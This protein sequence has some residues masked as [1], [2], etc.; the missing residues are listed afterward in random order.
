VGRGLL[1]GA[2]VI[3]AGGKLVL[4][5]YHGFMRLAVVLTIYDRLEVLPEQLKQLANQSDKDFDL[6]ICNNSTKN[7][8]HLKKIIDF[9]SVTYANKYIFFGRIFMIRDHI[10]PKGYDAIFTIDDDETLPANLIDQCKRQFHPNAIRSFWAFK[11]YDDYW[12]RKRLKG[13]QTG[14]YAGMGGCL[15]P[16][17][18]W[19]LEAIYEAP[20]ECW[21]VDDLW[22]SHC[23]LKHTN[24]AIKSLN[25]SMS[26][27]PSEGKKATYR[28]IKPFKSE[29]HEKYI[30]PYRK[31]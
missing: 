24:Y 2:G 29:I 16:A 1:D 11:T 21:M 4:V 17:K 5:I 9:E 18:F 23:V 20:E 6:W 25:V 10:L 31:N 13:S 30:K 26:F 27:I 7:I 19:R 14:D 12:K 28:K 15:T 3:P 8:E 22:I